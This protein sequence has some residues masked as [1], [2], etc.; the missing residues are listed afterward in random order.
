VRSAAKSD[1]SQR[2]NSLQS[3]FAIRFTVIYSSKS[4]LQVK[5]GC[6]SPVVPRGPEHRHNSAKLLAK[7]SLW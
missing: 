5:S 6:I 2:E 4:L 7:L 3:V 1:K